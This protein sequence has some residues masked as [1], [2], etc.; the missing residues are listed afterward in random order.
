[1]IDDI[2]QKLLFGV[3]PLTLDECRWLF[4]RATGESLVTKPRC[5]LC[6]ATGK[7]TRTSDIECPACAG[8][9]HLPPA[10]SLG[11]TAT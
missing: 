3:P 2:R 1:M 7:I 11:S 9:G 8:T 4:E 6:N 5:N 10:T